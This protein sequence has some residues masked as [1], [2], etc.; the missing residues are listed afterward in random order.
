MLDFLKEIV[1]GVADPSA[2]GT[3]DVDG[4]N[5]EG[6][7]RKRGKGK[8]GAIAGSKGTDPSAPKRRRKKAGDGLAQEDVPHP[9]AEAEA[10][11]GEPEGKS[12]QEDIAIDDADDYDENQ[13]V[14]GFGEFKPAPD[15]AVAVD[16]RDAEEDTPYMPGK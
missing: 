8:K 16:W 11:G 15:E 9:E 13:P 14:V 12:E 7:K 1:G 6:V 10:E 3:I 4:G 2:G 5:A